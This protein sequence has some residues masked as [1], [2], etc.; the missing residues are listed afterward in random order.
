LRTCVACRA[1][2]VTHLGCGLSLLDVLDRPL[3]CAVDFLFDF[4][5]S[6][7]PIQFILQNFI[8]L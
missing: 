1:H 5:E 2:G 6:G 3:D 8:S 7:A 4:V